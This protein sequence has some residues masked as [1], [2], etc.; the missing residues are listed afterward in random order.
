MA[1]KSKTPDGEKCERTLPFKL[2]DEDKARKG[3]EASKYNKQLEGAMEAKK[4]EMS[5]HNAKIA[6]LT[7]KV[8]AELKKINE[9]I[10]RRAVTCTAVKNFEKDVIEYWFEGM[11]LETTPMKPD[12]RQ[13]KMATD[14]KTDAKKSPAKWQKLAPKHRAKGYKDDDDQDTKDADIATVHKLET[15]RKGASSAVDP[16]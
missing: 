14:A 9:G 13:M 12:D 11:V 2:N 6:E 10:E 8:S 5:K 7:K 15:S 3:E 4:F 1:K 16:K